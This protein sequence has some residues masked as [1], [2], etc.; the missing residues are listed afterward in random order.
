LKGGKI[1]LAF[2]LLSIF[3][4]VSTN[5]RLIKKSQK[6]PLRTAEL[7]LP[8]TAPPSGLQQ[9]QEEIEN[10]VHDIQKYR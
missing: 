3:D 10:E 6:S 4:L 8:K 2:L 5:C 9:E 1:H 7:Q